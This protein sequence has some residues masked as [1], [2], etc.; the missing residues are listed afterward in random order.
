M[1]WD[2][3]PDPFFSTFGSWDLGLRPF[4]SWDLGPDPFLNLGPGTWDLGYLEG[5]WSILESRTKP[6]YLSREVYGDF[7]VAGERTVFYTVTTL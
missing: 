6:V 4:L 7:K 1:G 5:A 2:L 3:G